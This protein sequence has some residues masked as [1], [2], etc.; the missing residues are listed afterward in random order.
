MRLCCSNGSTHPRLLLLQSPAHPA[1]HCTAC[2]GPPAGVV[3]GCIPPVKGLFT[4]SPHP[5]LQLLSEAAG[6]LGQGLIPTTIPL[7]GAVLYR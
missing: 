7:L 2:L 4:G 5:P 1:L 6:T 3:V